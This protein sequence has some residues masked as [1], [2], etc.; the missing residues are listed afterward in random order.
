MLKQPHR[1]LI[2]PILLLV[3]AAAHGAIAAPPRTPGRQSA[4]PMRD[5]VVLNAYPH[6]PAAFT[7]GLAYHDRFL[8]EGTGLYGGTS[9]RRIDPKTGKVLQMQSL[10][11]HRFGEGIALR[12]NLIVQLTWRAGI[13]YVRD[14][15]TFEVLRTFRYYGEGWGITFDGTHFIMSD[16]S[17]KLRFLNPETFVVTSSLTVTDRGRPLRYLNELEFV[18][19]ELFANVWGI[20]R[21]ACISP[22]TGKVNAWIDLG[23]LRAVAAKEAAPGHPLGV[24]NGVAHDAAEDRLFVTGKKW[25][26]MFEIRLKKPK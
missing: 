5:Y 10:S 16:G 8:Y 17:A 14:R 21:I 3:V 1:W 6:D 13:G 25:P 24:L 4:M 9:I 26:L 15:E 18:G 7:Q 11:R 19:G 23:S 22:R 20:D 2:S 12:D